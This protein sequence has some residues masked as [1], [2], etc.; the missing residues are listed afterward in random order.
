MVKK[1]GRVFETYP[2]LRR[3]QFPF[4]DFSSIILEGYLVTKKECVDFNVKSEIDAEYLSFYARIIIPKDYMSKGVEVYDLYKKIDVDFIKKNYPQHLHF[5]ALNTV[6]GNLL[7]THISGCEKYC[8]NIIFEI[9]NSAHY[10]Y[11]NYVNL[12]N[13][14]PF[15]MKEYSHGSKGI[16]E[17]EKERL[18][19]NGKRKGNYLY[20]RNGNV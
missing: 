12:K 14:N 6:H 8:D 18:K 11:L 13:N 4:N 7:C 16:E 5:N 2:Y 20:K 10:Y 9:I 1:L 17:F 15:T 3:K 19:R